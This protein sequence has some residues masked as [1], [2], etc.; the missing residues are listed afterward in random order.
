MNPSLWRQARLNAVH[1]LFQACERTWQVRGLDLANMTIVGGDTGLI[2][3]D[4]LAGVEV[5][6]AA[7]ELCFAHQ[8]RRP[9]HT[10]I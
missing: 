4:P 5:A 2:V 8:P 1:G 3:I 7:H 10:V 6:R 9:V